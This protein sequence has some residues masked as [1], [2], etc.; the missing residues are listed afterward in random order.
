[1][2]GA[3]FHNMGVSPN[4]FQYLVAPMYSFGRQMVSGIAEFSYTSLPKT[5]I[6]VSRF[7]LS[8]KSFKND[9]SFARKQEGAYLALAPYWFAKIG[10][11]TNSPISHSF[12]LQ[13]IVK[14]DIQ[15]NTSTDYLG[16][17]AKYTFGVNKPDH[18]LSVNLRT[19]AV[20]SSETDMA[21][22][23]ADATYRF[24]YLKN[25]MK[26]WVEVRGFIGNTYHYKTSLGIKE[27]RMG[28]SMSGTDGQQ[29]LFFED[30]YFGR[31]LVVGMW[32]QQR[33]ENMGGFKSTANYGR[34]WN[35]MAAGNV[36][37]QLPI[38][39]IGIFGLFADLGTFHN[40]IALNSMINTGVGMR[41]GKVFGLYF[42][43]WMSKE[44]NNSYENSKY[45]EKIRF[46]LKMNIVNK[47]IKLSSLLN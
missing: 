6:K 7:G 29:D 12:L 43:I 45:A 37:V 19:D 9:S 40:G 21:R 30:Y 16:G 8:V 2:I 38:P 22:V 26:R 36:Y 32:S 17:F 14:A 46:T 39:K 20:F 33:D 47:G 10:N 15:S 34:T 28:M 42:P 3:A 24:R 5:S 11:R 25:T 18:K 4:R 23:T 41:F 31:G 35:W 13:G 44:L 27:D 1:M